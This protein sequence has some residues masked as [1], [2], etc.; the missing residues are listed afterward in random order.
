MVDND[1]T[2]YLIENTGK[3]EWEICTGTKSGGTLTRGTL[4]SSSTGSRVAFSSGIKKIK[5]LPAAS[6]MAVADNNGNW[7]FGTSTPAVFADFVNNWDGDAI[8]RIY[9]NHIGVATTARFD[10]ATGTANSYVITKVA[11]SNGSP[12]YQVAAGPGIIAAYYDMPAH[13]WR[14]VAG[15]EWMRLDVSGH[16]GIGRAAINGYPLEIY[17]VNGAGIQF[18][19]STY[20]VRMFMGEYDGGGGVG[21]GLVG[22]LSNHPVLLWVNNS[23]KARIDTS[24]NFIVG[25]TFAAAA[26][27]FTVYV[28]AGG[29][30]SVQATGTPYLQL[31]NTAG[32]VDQKYLRFGNTLGSFI[33]ET[34]NDTYTA[35]SERMRL[36]ASGNLMIGTSAAL[37]TIT[38]VIGDH[39]PAASGSMNSGVVWA[40]SLFSRALNIGVNNTGGYSWIN[41]AFANNSG[42]ADNL[43]LMTGGVEHFRVTGNG[44]IVSPAV[45]NSDAFIIYNASKSKFFTFK[46]EVLTNTAQWGYWIGS[47]WG[48]MTYSASNHIFI[49]NSSEQMRLSASGNLLIGTATD[50]GK[51]T[52]AQDPNTNWALDL[53]PCT[54]SVANGGNVQIA[55]G[56]GLIIVTNETNGQTAIYTCGGGSVT[57]VS[58]GGAGWSS[59]TGSPSAGNAS[60]AWTGSSYNLFN[61]YGSTVTFHIG[62]IRTRTSV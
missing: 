3:G 31:Y 11:D 9:N 8:L 38:A 12:F 16:L 44:A 15:S 51:V 43:V 22:T 52:V 47:G 26:S 37:G 61:N 27:T 40:T 62:L 53:A 57:M 2:D 18:T 4:I 14:N 21:R 29:C 34:V 46:P 41:A 58:A 59:P 60:I 5:M 56:S 23:E 19:D 45:D 24:G 30:A 36:D 35:S 32:G 39:G 7:G 48:Q 6:K 1:T 55:A 20:G 10:L 33:W 49:D 42:V 25:G 50:G 54:A 17:G 13:I 28:G